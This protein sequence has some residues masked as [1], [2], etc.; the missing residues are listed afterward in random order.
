MILKTL[1]KIYPSQS[2]TMLR[3][4]EKDIEKCINQGIDV[5]ELADST[6]KLI[7]TRIAADES[8]LKKED[9]SRPIPKVNEL[10]SFNISESNEETDNNYSEKT[11][12]IP[13]TN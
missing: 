6:V 3:T 5:S 9:D 10:S 12:E 11:T 2:D 8:N 7:M 1:R 4:I 13:K